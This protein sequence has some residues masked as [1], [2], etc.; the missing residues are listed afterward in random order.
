[1]FEL[2]MLYKNSK[3]KISHRANCK[4]KHDKI[5]IFENKSKKNFKK[6]KSNEK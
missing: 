3:Y 4:F 6:T 5:N 1:M 2:S